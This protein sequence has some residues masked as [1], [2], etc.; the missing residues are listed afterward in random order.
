MAHDALETANISAPAE[1]MLQSPWSWNSSYE[2]KRW[3][4]GFRKTQ[5]VICWYQLS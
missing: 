3:S 5:T 1:Q 4:L 2:T